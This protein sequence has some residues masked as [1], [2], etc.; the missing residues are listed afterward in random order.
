MNSLIRR[1]VERGIQ[2]VL[3]RGVERGLQGGLSGLR[4]GCA[5]RWWIFLLVAVVGCCLVVGLTSGVLNGIGGLLGGGGGSTGSTSGGTNLGN[6]V[7][8]GRLVTATATNRDGCAD[9][10]TSRFRGE[11]AIWV[12]AESSDFPRGTRVFMRLYRGTRAVED[13][14]EI[15]ADKDYR[16]ACISFVFEASR[17]A[18]VLEAGDYE[19][20]LY[21]NGNAAGSVKFTVD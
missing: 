9:G 1:L 14:D 21:V 7:Q 12:V 11:E 16:N 4:G 17:S 3:Q 19:A 5:S 6:G 10:R 15:V 8:I 20:E 18:G 2:R 13:A